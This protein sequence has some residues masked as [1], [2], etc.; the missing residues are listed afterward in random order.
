[1]TNK[2][3]ANTKTSNTRN[4]QTNMRNNERSLHRKHI[5]FELNLLFSKYLGIFIFCFVHLT[6]A[7]G[8]ASHKFRCLSV[9]RFRNEQFIAFELK[10]FLWSYANIDFGLYKNILAIYEQIVFSLKTFSTRVL[11]RPSGPHERLTCREAPLSY[12][13]IFYSGY[14]ACKS[15]RIKPTFASV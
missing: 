10:I 14:I 1:M 12:V 9:C 8:E 7:F 2:L 11:F 15:R 13:A 5:N 3:V 4:C 6:P